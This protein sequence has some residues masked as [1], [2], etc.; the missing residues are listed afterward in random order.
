[1]NKYG[2]KI[3]N[4]R[5]IRFW[6]SFSEGIEGKKFIIMIMIIM[7]MIIIIIRESG[8]FMNRIMQ[9]VFF[10]VSYAVLTLWV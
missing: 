3:S 8:K 2:Q 10:P 5:G 9:S 4:C 7:M 6:K 1:M